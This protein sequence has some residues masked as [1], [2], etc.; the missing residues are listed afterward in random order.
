[1]LT[2]SSELQE[3]AELLRR[4]MPHTQKHPHRTVLVQDAERGFPRKNAVPSG[5]DP[6]PAPPPEPGIVGTTAPLERMEVEGHYTEEKLGNLLKHMCQQGGY[7]YSV[8]FDKNGFILGKYGSRY[9]DQKSSALAALLT[10]AKE[11]LHGLLENGN[12]GSLIWELSAQEKLVFSHFEL[13]DMQL[14]L[15]TI[16]PKDREIQ[17]VLDLTISEIKG[18]LTP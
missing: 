11:K 13:R 1:M 9:E 17:R 12:Q 18:V 8:L 7:T 16:S 5:G 14:Y 3:A 4:L 2:D 10:T 6:H 15:L